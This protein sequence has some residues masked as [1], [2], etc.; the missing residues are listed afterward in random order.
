M[1]QHSDAYWMIRALAEAARGRGAVEPNPM[2][3]AVVVR[4][5]TLVGLGHH[6]RF[7]GPHAEVV[8]LHSAG[9]AARGATL[10][11]T[12]EPCCHHGKTPP[13]TDAVLASGV[14]RV[15]AAMPDPFPRVAGG[16]L[17]RLRDAGVLVEVGV[18]ADAARRLNA[19]YLKR[20]STGLPYVIA[21]WAMTLDG[22]IATSTGDSVWISGPESRALVHETRGRVDAIA[23]GIGTALADDPRLTA[24]PAGPRVARRV[25]LDAAARLPLNSRLVRSARE[26]PVLIAVTDRAPGERREA[27]AAAGCEVLHLAGNGQVSIELLLAELGRKGATNLLVEGGARVL[28]SFFDTGQVDEVDVYLAPILLGGASDVPAVQGASNADRMAEALRLDQTTVSRVGADVR[29]Q[30]TISRPWRA[31]WGDGTPHVR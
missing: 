13:C 30:G 15:V 8:A 14:A 4:E 26:A 20:L 10:F 23:V 17:S 1:S 21:K 28:G 6:A 12:L 18:E 22:K 29:V 3:G 31:G 19:P 11:V 25:V 2:V 9:D 16:G 7:G 5:G 24:R 27:L